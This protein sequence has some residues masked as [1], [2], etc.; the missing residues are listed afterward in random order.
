MAATNNDFTGQP[1]SVGKFLLRGECYWQH[2]ADNDN[3]C[4][5]FRVPFNSVNS[6]PQNGSRRET[7]Y[8]PVDVC[9]VNDRCEMWGFNCT[10]VTWR[11]STRQ[12]R[13]AASGGFSQSWLWNSP[14]SCV[15]T[16]GR[17]SWCTADDDAKCLPSLIPWLTADNCTKNTS[18]IIDRNDWLVN[19][20]PIIILTITL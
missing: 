4:F 6:M 17:T 14:G 12:C 5:E 11:S 20:G 19:K 8:V 7:Q 1:V 3:Q 2:A 13:W 18:T 15:D 16:T 10:L 9:D